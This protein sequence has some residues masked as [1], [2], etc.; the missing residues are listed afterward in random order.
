M[1]GTVLV[2][3][4]SGLFG[5][6]TAQAFAAA[7]W[8]VRNYKRGTDMNAVAI[9]ADVIVNGLNPPM[10][11]DW[12][13]LIPQLTAQVI[14]AG[15]A[16]GATVVVPGNVYPYGDQPAPWGPDTV[17]RPVSRKGHI[18]KAMEAAYRSSEVRVLLLRGGDFLDEAKPTTAMNMVALKSAPRGKIALMG[19]SDVPRAYAYLPDMAR[20]AVALADIRA[21]LPL[22][23]DV[24]FAG[25]TFSM[26]ALRDELVRQTGRS[27][28]YTAFPWWFMRAAA[29]FWELARELVEMRYLMNTPH[30]LD[31]APMAA[32]L[33][34]FNMT[35]FSE[36]VA[37]HIKALKLGQRDLHPNRAV[38]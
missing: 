16:S 38:A 32:L 36:V 8:Q 28:R 31:P 25:L 35:P 24:P 15:K 26:D 3:G 13:R 2:L 6:R 33:P 1:T 34:Q 9:G 21:Q 30:Q 14:A 27:F 19:K 5:S 18:R 12:A 22:F 23:A 29:P 17:Q 20:A 11:H 4:A 10:Y 7:G 37:A